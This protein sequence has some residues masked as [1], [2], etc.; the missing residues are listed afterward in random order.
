MLVLGPYEVMT[1]TEYAKR[2]GSDVRSILG[3][4]QRAI[5]RTAGGYVDGV[6]VWVQATDVRYG[7]RPG[8]LACKSG[9]HDSEYTGL[10]IIALKK[11]ES[12]NG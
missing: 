5:E 8:F 4:I 7:V 6:T 10:W 9:S 12:T 3:R 2:F 11:K 1:T